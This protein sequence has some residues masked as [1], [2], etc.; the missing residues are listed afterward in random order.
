MKKDSMAICIMNGAPLDDM[1]VIDAHAH[2]GLY[3]LFYSSGGEFDN[4][5][6]SMDRYGIDVICVSHTLG[7]CTDAEQANNETLKC[8]QSYP[9]KVLGY[10]FING[11]DSPK[12]IGEMITKYLGMNGFIGVKIY[13][14]QGHDS[15]NHNTSINDRNYET[16]WKMASEMGFIILSHTGGSGGEPSAPGRFGSIL[17]EYPDIK[18]ILGHSGGTYK[19]QMETLDLISRYM[20]VYYDMTASSEG[21]IWLE[22]ITGMIGSDKV[23]YGSDYGFFRPELE[24]G[25]VAFSNIDIEAKK[26][27]MGYNMKKLIE[28]TGLYNFDIS[29]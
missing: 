26:K 9:G 25:R 13:P 21:D 5:V 7:I 23:L 16:V 24:I 2:G 22:D 3:P 10:C 8:I 20:N 1:L 12:T 4:I 28:S 17:K 18:L 14:G 29:R 19:G 11:N 27:I 6:G 15:R